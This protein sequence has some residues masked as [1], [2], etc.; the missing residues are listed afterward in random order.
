MSGRVQSL[1]P[2]ASVRLPRSQDTVSR[3]ASNHNRQLPG[4]QP[5]LNVKELAQPLGNNENLEC[6]PVKPVSEDDFRDL[7]TNSEAAGRFERLREAVLR[8]GG[9]K[10]VSAASGV[11]ASTLGVYLAGGSWKL[12]TALA[13][14]QACETSLEWIVTGVGPRELGR[15]TGSVSVIG[16][17]E[18][19]GGGNVALHEYAIVPRFDVRASAGK[20]N[21][22]EGEELKGYLALEENF[23]RQVL[24]RRSQD[25]V[26]IEATGDSMEPGIHD[27]DL[28]V[29][30]TSVQDV[31]NSRVYVLDVNGELLVKRL[32]LRLDGAVIVRSDNAK[33]EAE[34]VLPSDRNTLRIIG[35]VIYQAGPVRS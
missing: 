25:M 5:A 12:D 7:A 22:V 28:L 13:L 31:Q 21:Q 30:D 33:Y 27:G 9:N 35:Q 2:G 6:D 23:L 11:P 20:G 29:V 4:Y 34:T 19:E 26:S 24:N 10:V 8:A 16:T 17:G 14:A 32:S 3:M 18:T 1:F 15:R